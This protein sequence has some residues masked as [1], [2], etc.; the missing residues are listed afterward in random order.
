MRGMHLKTFQKKELQIT[1]KT[2]EATKNVLDQSIAVV[3]TMH[4][5]LNPDF[6][7][8]QP[9]PA[10]VLMVLGTNVVTGLVVDMPRYGKVDSKT[11]TRAVVLIEEGYSYC[12]VGT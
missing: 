12:A 2:L 10:T 9:T 6:P 4:C 11:R 7:S 1:R 3:R 5:D 8:D